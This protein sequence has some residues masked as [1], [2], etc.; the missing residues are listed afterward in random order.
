MGEKRPGDLLPQFNSRETTW[1]PPR[2]L[3]SLDRLEKVVLPGAT[4]RC[5][6]WPD[7]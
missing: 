1:D 5:S 3:D 7:S 2:H 4:Q 6:F